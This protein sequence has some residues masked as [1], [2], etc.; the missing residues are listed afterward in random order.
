MLYQIYERFLRLPEVQEDASFTSGH[1]I[2]K[3]TKAA[4]GHSLEHA[5]ALEHV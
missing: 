5:Q 2:Y 4:I 1:P 3:R